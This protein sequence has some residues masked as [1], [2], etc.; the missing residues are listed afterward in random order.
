[1]TLPA[2]QSRK[3]SPAKG[4]GSSV[5]RLPFFESDAAV[6]SAIRA[7]QSAGGAAL[8]DRHREH[9]QRVLLRVLGPDADLRDL[10][11]DVFLAAID[12]IERLEQPDALRGW[13]ASIAVHQAR[14]EIRKRARGRW[15][16][17]FANDDLPEV[18]ANVSTPE[19]DEAVRAT[20]RILG[21]LPADER[22]AFSLRFIDGM[23]LVE[24]ADI[25]GVSLATI[26]RRL[27][28]AQ[29]KFV[30]MARTY[31][32]LSEYLGGVHRWR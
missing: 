27:A 6:V 26:K 13:L 15:F 12:S 31:P 16:P 14:A 23:E 10:V 20:Y 28:L 11:Q 7:G 21:K 3:Q 25:C 18:E 24:V 30:T 8:Y 1:M 19:V 22:I 2:P 5:V 32:E 4:A 17:L 9:V 29:K